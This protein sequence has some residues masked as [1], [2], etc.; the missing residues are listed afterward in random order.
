MASPLPILLGLGALILVASGGGGSPGGPAAKSEA[1]KAGYADGYKDAAAK[2]PTKTYEQAQKSPEAVASGNASDYADGYLVG[3]V[4]GAV[5]A[6]KSGGGGGGTTTYVCKTADAKHSVLDYQKALIAAK[7]MTPT[8]VKTGKSNADGVCGP[9][10]IAAIA[11]FQTKKGLPVT[12]VIDKATAQLL[13]AMIEVVADVTIWRLFPKSLILETVEDKSAILG[14]YFVCTDDRPE[15]AAFD[16]KIDTTVSAVRLSSGS[17]QITAVHYANKCG[18]KV[19]D[20]A[21]KMKW[22]GSAWVSDLS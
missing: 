20:Y 12:K 14:D 18:V 13:D 9:I 1:Y 7:S 17:Y 11:D 5:A 3:R 21:V 2:K 22:D 6:T 19:G 15:S 16:P 8:N 4:D 10:T